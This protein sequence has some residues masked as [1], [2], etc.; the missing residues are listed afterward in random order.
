MPLRGGSAYPEGGREKNKG[1]KKFAHRHSEARAKE[2]GENIY[3]FPEKRE[4]G[5]PSRERISP[6]KKRI[7]L[8][9]EGKGKQSGCRLPEKEKEKEIK[10]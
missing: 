2:G 9:H 3:S 1:G 7:L 10:R 6:T 5:N 8:I 4:N